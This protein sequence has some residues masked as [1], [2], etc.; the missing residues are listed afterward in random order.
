M[1]LKMK[2][3]LV[4]FIA[5]LKKSLLLRSLHAL[6]KNHAL[7]ADSRIFTVKKENCQDRKNLPGKNIEY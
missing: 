7:E 2:K 5:G 6:N 4:K 3:W 1:T